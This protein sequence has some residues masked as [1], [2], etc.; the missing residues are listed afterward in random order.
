MN[1]NLQRNNE[2]LAKMHKI[3]RQTLLA[4]RQAI[5]QKWQQNTANNKIKSANRLDE[6]YSHIDNPIHPSNPQSVF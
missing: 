2:K 6:V 5:P 1:E 3:T 4:D